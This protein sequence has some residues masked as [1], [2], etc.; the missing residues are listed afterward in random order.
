MGKAVGT[1]LGNPQKAA[2][3][4]DPDAPGAPPLRRHGLA[5]VEAGRRPGVQVQDRQI[6]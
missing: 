4:I 3:A 1:H 2:L 6:A 5:V